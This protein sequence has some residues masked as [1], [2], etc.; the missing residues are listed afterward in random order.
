MHLKLCESLLLLSL[1]PAE[2]LNRTAMDKSSTNH[3]ERA[4]TGPEDE[5]REVQ[6]RPT[7]GHFYFVLASSSAHSQRS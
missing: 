6:G 5:S 1:D 7:L 3:G 4:G 2:S